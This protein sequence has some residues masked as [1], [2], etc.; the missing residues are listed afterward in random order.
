VILPWYLPSW[1]V[2]YI[3]GQI[4]VQPFIH[5]YSLSM[6]HLFFVQLSMGTPSFY[7]WMEVRSILLATRFICGDW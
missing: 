2:P 7:L 1:L 6:V 3:I 4:P 5:V